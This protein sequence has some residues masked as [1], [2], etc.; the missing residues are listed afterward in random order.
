[1]NVFAGKWVIAARIP[2]IALILDGEGAATRYAMPIEQESEFI[3]IGAPHTAIGSRREE[4]DLAGLN[5]KSCNRMAV[6]QS[7]TSR[8]CC[9]AL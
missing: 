2:G 3:A 1:V 8:S 6:C 5:G 9:R 4:H 7:S